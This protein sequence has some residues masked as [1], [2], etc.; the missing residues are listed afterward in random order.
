MGIGYH[1]DS[2]ARVIQVFPDAVLKIHSVDPVDSIVS[3]D[4]NG[5]RKIRLRFNK[6]IDQW[7]DNLNYFDIRDV[8]HQRLDFS[9]EIINNDAILTLTNPGQLSD[10]AQLFVTARKG[11]ANVKQLTANVHTVLYELARDVALNF[12]YRE[13]DEQIARLDAVVP[14][15]MQLNEHK[16]SRSRV[17]AW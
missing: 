14:R 11:L 13:T 12:V 9:T 16:C 3:L 5:E 10:G 6:A 8:S 1:T 4:T 17:S 2:H 15:R 7:L